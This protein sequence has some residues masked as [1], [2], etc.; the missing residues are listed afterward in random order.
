MKNMVPS[1]QL[2][3]ASCLQ[4]LGWSMMKKG[5][6]I[7]VKRYR[8][9]PD[10]YSRV[11]TFHVYCVCYIP[12]VFNEECLKCRE[13][14]HSDTCYSLSR[15]SAADSNCGMARSVDYKQNFTSI[16]II[17]LCVMT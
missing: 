10:T 4:D 3:K 9:V 7:L 1:E 5:C 17:L 6:S 12:E 11:D 13:W 8:C 14:Y 15:F 2:M 16:V